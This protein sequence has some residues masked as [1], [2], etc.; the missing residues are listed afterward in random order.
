MS[1]EFNQKLRQKISD[2]ILSGEDWDNICGAIGYSA[3]TSVNW[4]THFMKIIYLKLLDGHK[5]FIPA[6][7]VALDKDNFKEFIVSRFDDFI[8]NKAIHCDIN[9]D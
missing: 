7:N 3:A 2:N 4:A 6:L 1:E 9:Q 5:I 8:Y